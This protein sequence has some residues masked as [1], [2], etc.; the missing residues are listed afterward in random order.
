MVISIGNLDNILD[1]KE[2]R[3]LYQGPIQQTVSKT[4]CLQTVSKTELASQTLRGN[5]SLPSSSSILS[6]T[7]N[8][9]RKRK[10]VDTYSDDNDSRTS[11]SARNRKQR[12]K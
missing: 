7:E 2:R 10:I 4:E 3:A 1:E 9:D 8:T 11:K 6:Y 12:Q 5:V